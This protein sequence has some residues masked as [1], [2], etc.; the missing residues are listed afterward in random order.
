M[1]EVQ[2]TVSEKRAQRSVRWE[3]NTPLIFKSV[4]ACLAL[5]LVASVLYW[6]Q[7]RQI[8]SSV[9]DKAQAAEANQ[10]WEEQ[11]RWLKRYRLLHPDD[12]EGTVLLALAADNAVDTAPAN[13][14]ERIERARRTLRDALASLQQQERTPDAA[15]QESGLR[16]R[17]IKRLLQYGPRY[18]DEA[19]R[20]IIQLAPPHFDAEMLRSMAL[21]RVGQFALENDDHRDPKKHAEKTQFWRWFSQQPLGDVVHI[22]W[23]ANRDDLD[24]AATLID[25]CLNHPESFSPPKEGAAASALTQWVEKVRAEVIAHLEVKHDNGHAQWIVYRYL[26]QT[27]PEQ[28]QERIQSIVASALRRLQNHAETEKTQ[29]ASDATSLVATS[30][31]AAAYSPRWDYELVL[32]STAAGIQANA[33]EAQQSV[34][35]DRLDT[36]ITLT[37]MEVPA[38]LIEAVHLQRGQQHWR[39]N[40]PQQAIELWQRGITRLADDS[41]QLQLTHASALAEQ[42]TVAEATA[43]ISKLSGLLRRSAS[44]LAGPT[45]AHMTRGQRAAAQSTLDHATWN[46][47]L[48]RGQIA[49]REH[50]LQTAISLLHAALD[51]QF[52]MPDEQRVRAAVLVATAYER[53]GAWDLAATAYERAIHL[54]PGNPQY[55][56]D[57]ARAWAASGD[58]NRSRQQWQSIGGTSLG[59]LVARAQ[60]LVRVQMA[61]PPAQRDF[62]AVTRD[63]EKLRRSVAQLPDSQAAERGQLEAQLELLA[64][65]IPDSENGQQ[66]EQAID[67][68]ATLAERFPK[69]TE[70]QSVAALSLAT[71]GQAQRSQAAMERLRQI[72]GD[73][74]LTYHK[75]LA[76]CL[77]AAGSRD[78]AIQQLVQHAEAIPADAAECLTLA[79]DIAQAKQASRK[80][81]GNQQDAG[82]PS[83]L[84]GLGPAELLG[85]IP[86][87]QRTPEHLFRLFTLALANPTLANPADPA[88]TANPV[89]DS[90]SP[91]REALRWEQELRQY[92]GEQGSWWRLAQATRLQAE[93]DRLD[94]NDPK[95][96]RLLGTASELQT[97]IRNTRP[98]WGL[99]LSLEGTIA[100]RLGE[101]QRAIDA[102]R[103]GIDSGDQRVTTLLLLV[104][105]LNRANRVAEA[106]AEL[107]RFERMLDTHSTITALAVAIAAKK[108]DYSQGLDLA[109]AGTKH[110]PGDT[111]AWLILG[112]TAARAAQATEQTETRAR[113]VG[114]AKQAYD[115]ALAAS[116]DSSLQ[117]YQLRVRLQAAFFGNE[118]VHLEL[119]QALRSKIAEPTRSLFV[120]LAY[121]ELNDF[122]AALP[123]LNHALQVAPQDPNVYV[124][125]SQYHQARREDPK[126]IEMLEQ[127][128]QLAPD[129]ADIRNRLALTI[130]LRDGGNVP[131]ERLAELLK[132]ETAASSQNQLLYALILI[133][134]GDQEQQREA[135]AILDRLIRTGGHDS[136]DAMRMLAALERRRWANA[137]GGPQ[138]PD[139]QRAFAEARRHY[140]ALT[141]RDEPEV[142]DL[143]RFAD[144]LLRADQ[145]ADVA[146]LADRLD[147]I[148]NG[149]PIGL[150]IRLRLARKQG[151]DVRAAELTKAWTEQT[152]QSGTMLQAG[153]WETAGRTLSNL[154]YH[155]EAL[156]WLEQ[157]YQENRDTFRVFVIALARGKQ[158]P[159][160]LEICQAHYQATRQ[161]DAVALMADVVTIQGDIQNVPAEIDAIFDDAIKRFANVPRLIESIA[162]L[163]LSQQR[164][165]EA[166]ALYEKAEQLAPDNVRVLNNL[167]MALS[168]IAGR[169]A[170]AVSRIQK[171]ID[172]YGRSPELLDTQGL[173]LLRNGRI[174]EAISIL[175]EATSGSDDPRYRFHLL[176][177]LMRAGDKVESRAQW[178]KLN[179]RAL[180]ETVLTPAER[181]DFEIMQ[182]EFANRQS[183]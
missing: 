176:M 113:L 180:K 111:N 10:D 49:L 177:A 71:A 99:G 104:D 134:R 130:A 152:V 4:A 15:S 90:D 132:N 63:L 36:L 146:P 103:R 151:D 33:T 125:L 110:N 48:L 40:E 171:A 89:G 116:G 179:V 137:K 170:S 50:K 154:G 91:F 93:W 150:D 163:R 131:W 92:E 67:R 159:R 32:L 66:R 149:A 121:V 70:L 164:Y 69:N 45:G 133:N 30:P 86:E 20:Q 124:A 62:A 74:A 109:R 161:P 39:A 25:Q 168:E 162:T 138:S 136:D 57:A 12:S 112:Q 1:T 156:E 128:Y 143:Y 43:A 85:R 115:Q 126:T 14:P 105:Q 129:R 175:R 87:D 157:A 18:A 84:G 148:S 165:P 73:D 83:E 56:V 76:R 26:Q 140:T 98:R 7:S 139:A 127:A 6:M 108:G 119:Q 82:G 17:L 169:E 37:E 5:A 24:L 21:A 3:W 135:A 155:E 172:L 47:R 42:G 13:Q 102:L 23:D 46:M 34:A 9:M 182:Q 54:D 60:A 31:V 79:A 145:I 106:E 16:R 147:A 117:A 107:S 167:A 11:I 64:L 52:P 101:S 51:S 97:A 118:E 94:A 61:L 53:S 88:A 38:A 183:S 153:A 77:V 122:A 178:A 160:A 22:A 120:G 141:R 55:R 173:V 80:P 144:L 114:E 27:S 41:L 72:V 8:A 174:D 65:A 181:R 142:M 81:A 29:P 78:E 58:T 158:F 166:V 95:R 75:T 100:A 28:A 2:R 35:R 59:V 19:E 44:D 68:L 123:A 96:S